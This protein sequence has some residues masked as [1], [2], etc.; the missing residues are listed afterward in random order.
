MKQCWALKPSDRPEIPV[1]IESL[2]G[3]CDEL[4]GDDRGSARVLRFAALSA[5]S[6]FERPTR[7]LLSGDWRR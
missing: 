3:L 5:V 4:S 1:V 2:E 6:V 7:W